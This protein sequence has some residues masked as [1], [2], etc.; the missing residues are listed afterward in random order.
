MAR[1][2]NLKNFLTD[3]ASAIRTKGGTSDTIKAAN[4][5]ILIKEFA[6]QIQCIHKHS[7]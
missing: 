7:L 2:D 6:N 4:F 3:V 5:D 1:T